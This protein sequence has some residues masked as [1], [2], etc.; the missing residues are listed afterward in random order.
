MHLRINAVIQIHDTQCVKTTD[1]INCTSMFHGSRDRH[2]RR[3][4]RRSR[5]EP[6][7]ASSGADR[8]DRAD[9]RSDT[10]LS[11]DLADEPDPTVADKI[12]SMPAGIVLTPDARFK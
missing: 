11:D 12:H 4:L 7:G 1:N 10:A 8:L 3:A 5:K 2:A 9:D 6:N